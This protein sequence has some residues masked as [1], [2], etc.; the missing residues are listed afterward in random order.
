[1]AVESLSLSCLQQLKECLE[2][3]QGRI[4]RVQQHLSKVQ[5]HL[6]KVQVQMGDTLKVMEMM[7]QRLNWRSH[8]EILYSLG[9]CRF[10]V[11]KLI[12]ALTTHARPSKRQWVTYQYA[13]DHHILCKSA[14]CFLHC[15]VE[16]SSRIFTS[17]SKITVLFLV[18]ME[19]RVAF[20]Q[21]VL[22]LTLPRILWISSQT[23]PQCL[24]YHSQQQE[25]GVR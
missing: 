9:S 25:E 11:R 3:D 17:I 5:Q 24:V 12:L 2:R 23:M 8:R 4:E 6:S 21:M 7:S 16:K 13:Y 22:P 1:M 18:N 19:T 15:I 20:L 10:L 14:F